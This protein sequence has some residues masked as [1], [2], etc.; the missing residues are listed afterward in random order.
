MR[1]FMT[2][3][4]GY[5]GSVMAPLLGEAGHEVVGLDAYLYEG[6]GFGPD[7]STSA[8]RAR[9]KDVRDVGSADL[10]DFDAVVHLAAL[11]NDPLGDLNARLTYAVNHRATV[12]LA[13]AAREAGVERFLLASSCS[14][15]GAAGGDAL[16]DESSEVDPLTPYAESKIRAEADVSQLADG[17]FSPTHLRNATVY[18]VS[19]RLRTDVVLNNLVGLAH[20]DGEIVLRSDGN[21]WRPLVHV[22]DLCRAFLAVLEAPREAVHDETFNVGRTSENYRVRELADLVAEAMPGTR[23]GFARDAAYDERSYR[24]DFSKLE[25]G[26]AGYRPRWTV[27]DGIEELRD[28]YERHGLDRNDL[29]DRHVR[30]RRVRSLLERELLDEELRWSEPRPG[31]EHRQCLQRA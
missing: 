22:E 25:T 6:C 4:H 12:R 13:E 8:I 20:V 18:G 26:L 24:V 28:A 7:P 9:R 16:L 1:I 2:G 14:L 31:G 23:V 27:R 19:P 3:H 17:D 30:V 10:D 15:Y 11:S 29:T 21:S 5:I